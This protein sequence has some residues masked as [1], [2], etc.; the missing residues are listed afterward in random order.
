MD[1][2]PCHSKSMHYKFLM[3]LEIPNGFLSNISQCIE[4]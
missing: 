2:I 1:I 4:K 3:V